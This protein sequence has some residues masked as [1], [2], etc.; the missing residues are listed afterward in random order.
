MNKKL[1]I[2]LVLFFNVYIFQAQCAY[3]A[4]AT[5]VGTYTF[6]VDNATTTIITANVTAGQYALVNVVKGFSY[7]FSVG[8]INNGSEQENL[9]LFNAS[10]DLA[11]TPS[12]YNESKKVYF[13]EIVRVLTPEEVTV[14]FH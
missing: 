1:L 7:T 3:P 12:G 5:S 9:T 4:A 6:C 10:N 13:Q 11:F 2:L 8:D 14:L